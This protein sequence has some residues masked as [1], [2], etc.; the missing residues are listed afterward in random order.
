MTNEEI[1]KLNGGKK[2][3]IV[4]MNPPYA[5]AENG[6]VYLD[7]QFVKKTNEIANNVIA[8]HPLSRWSSNTKLGKTN[9]DGKHLKIVE[10]IEADKYFDISLAA[11]YL[12]IYYYDNLKEYNNTT[13]LF[14]GEQTSVELNIESRIESFKEIKI[15]NNTI[16]KII[17]DKKDL[18]NELKDKYNTMVNDGHGFVY[19]ENRMHYGKRFGANK[20]DQQ[21]LS[22]VKEYLKSGKYKYCLY[23]GSFNNEYNKVQEWDEQDPDKLFRGQ[24]CWL[25][26]SK[27]VKNNMKYW[28]ECPLFDLWRR[29]NIPVGTASNGCAYGMLPALDFEQPESDFRKYVDSLN[30]FTVDEIEELKKFKVHNADKLTND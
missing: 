15:N 24:I 29:Y 16:T 30:D 28:M 26:N 20:D 7:M 11:K 6:A 12:V 23:K 17:R 25:M 22:R 9:A 27:R 19:D 10:A 21:S 1:L 14:N 13:L 2:F 3:D 4:L 5:G 18:Y 8:I